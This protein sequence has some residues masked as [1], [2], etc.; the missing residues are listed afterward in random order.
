MDR[1]ITYG[2]LVLLVVLIALAA[3]LDS[4]IIQPAP[5]P[6]SSVTATLEP[7]WSVDGASINFIRIE[8]LNAGMHVEVQKN[9]KGTWMVMDIPSAEANQTSVTS[10]VTSLAKVEVY[11]EHGT[12]LELEIFDLDKPNYKL[13][14]KTSEG[15][16]FVLEIG[17]MNPTQTGYY[18]R[19]EGSPKII[20][21]R[22]T[23]LSGVIGWISNKPLPPTITPTFTITPT[24]T[25]TPT[26][27][28]TPTLTPTETATPTETPTVTPTPSMAPATPTAS[29]TS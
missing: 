25:T 26:I 5:T 24:N 18:A 12:D 19:I 13:T 17:A 27:T 2:L 22:T 23:F 1:R 11:R 7:L 16:S 4:N 10:V 8:D 20:S 21:V 14:V 15:K 28:R 29:P 6:A 9:T 3:L